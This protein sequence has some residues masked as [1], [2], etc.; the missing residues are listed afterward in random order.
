MNDGG[1]LGVWLF[2]T[3]VPSVAIVS[4]FWYVRSREQI[5]HELI[6]KVLESGRAVDSAT[7]DK[8]LCRPSATAR[9]FVNPVAD[10]RDGPALL[11]KVLRHLSGCGGPDTSRCSGCHSQRHSQRRRMKPTASGAAMSAAAEAGLK[12]QPRIM[13]VSLEAG[14]APDPR[15]TGGGDASRECYQGW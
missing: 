10:P 12:R 1:A 15:A 6:L 2:L 7:R 11:L 13:V 14:V 4:V 3:V 9:P 8:L 5:R